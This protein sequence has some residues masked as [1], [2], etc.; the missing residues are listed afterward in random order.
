MRSLLS[1]LL[2]LPGVLAIG[3]KP[4]VNFNASGSLL[5]SQSSFVTINADQNE[6][7]A[8][9]R[10]CDDLAMDFGLVTGTNGSVMLHGDGMSAMNASMIFNVTGRSS[11]GIMSSATTPGGTIIAG[12]IG[13]SSLIDDLIAQGKLDVTEIRGSWE[14]YVSSVVS[15][16]MPGVSQ[17]LVIAGQLRSRVLG[18]KA[19]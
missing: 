16:P 15:D 14:S 11:F 9:L 3:Q 18:C 1:T 8:V 5:A 4:V 19:Y 13:N 12:T 2:L 6:W 7:P 17:A 10:V